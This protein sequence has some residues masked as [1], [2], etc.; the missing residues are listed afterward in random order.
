MNID[1]TKSS[2]PRSG[3]SAP[4]SLSSIFTDA[5]PSGGSNSSSAASASAP[6]PSNVLLFDINLGSLVNAPVLERSDVLAYQQW[7]IS[8]ETWAMTTGVW[9]VVNT[10]VTTM[11][12]E[13]V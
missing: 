1:T 9:D 6:R 2:A 4:P 12:Q 11:A 3:P 5:Q 10:D 13:A 7:K 8:F